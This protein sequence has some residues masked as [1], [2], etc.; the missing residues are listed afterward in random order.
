MSAATENKQ[1]EDEKLSQQLSDIKETL[2]KMEGSQE[3][4]FELIDSCNS[5]INKIKDKITSMEESHRRAI[6]D[7]NAE[8]DSI[9]DRNGSDHF[10]YDDQFYDYAGNVSYEDE[11]NRESYPIPGV[12]FSLM[13]EPD[14]LE[15]YRNNKLQ[16]ERRNMARRAKRM[17]RRAW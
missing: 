10:E 17:A 2:A 1:K 3:R 4:I 5:T 9:I 12:P 14:D 7:L 15:R 11:M 13:P 8:I 16:I 6:S